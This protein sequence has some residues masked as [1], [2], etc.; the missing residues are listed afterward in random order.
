MGVAAAFKPPD[1]AASYK[2]VF[3]CQGWTDPCCDAHDP[4]PWEP[5]TEVPC[6]CELPRRRCRSKAAASSRRRRATH[7]SSSLPAQFAPVAC[8]TFAHQT[9]HSRA[10]QQCR[11]KVPGSSPACCMVTRWALVSQCCSSCLLDRNV[12]LHTV[13]ITYAP[14]PFS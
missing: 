2:L 1:S 12:R 14:T 5:H 3:A 8:H 6:D 7:K 4:A 9:P 10:G 11:S 13:Q